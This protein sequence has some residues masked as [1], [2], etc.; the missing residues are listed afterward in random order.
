MDAST[1]RNLQRASGSARVRVARSADA[2]RL[3]VLY[4]EGAAKIRLPRDRRR[5]WA[6]A[7]L[8][9]TAGGLTG[10]DRIGWETEAAAGTM[11]VVTTQACEKVYRAS[12][13][14]AEVEARL[15]AGVGAHLA[16]L[17]QETILFNESA[18]QRRIDVE[19]A[20]DATCLILEPVI[21]GRQAMGEEVRET[22]LHD[23]W[24][25]RCD[26]ALVHA[27]DLR[28]EGDAAALMARAAI[29]GGAGAMAS[30]LY[31]GA[32]A[33]DR[34]CGVRSFLKNS[35]DGSAAANAWRSGGTGK[36]LARILAKDGFSLRRVVM[37]LAE[38]LNRQAG[39]PRIWTN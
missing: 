2:T 31:V 26:G 20:P 25:V 24:R 37:P 30:L 15:I 28:V 39:L 3:D 10:G 33:E 7:V 12:G 21:F 9:N 16:W 5:A 34:L 32:D 22:V 4:Q 6:E 35:P 36:L 17:P 23:R 14:I 13:G 29:G 19:I 18:L 27:E 1:H 38:M 11:L 8:I